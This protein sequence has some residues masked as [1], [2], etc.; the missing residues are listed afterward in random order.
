MPLNEGM[1]RYLAKFPSTLPSLI[2]M[3]IMVM[4]V[5]HSLGALNAYRECVCV[6]NVSDFDHD[7]DLDTCGDFR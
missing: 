7:I 4:V 5:I 6:V 2:M 3:A 1:P